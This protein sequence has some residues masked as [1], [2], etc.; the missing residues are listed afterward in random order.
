M[1]T[2]YSGKLLQFN[3]RLRTSGK[4]L[5]VLSV[6]L[7]LSILILS[8]VM[9]IQIQSLRSNVQITQNIINANIRTLGQTQ[10]EFLRLKIALLDGSDSN[11]IEQYRAFTSQRVQEVTLS[12]NE[13]TL[14]AEHLLELADE[15]ALEWSNNIEPLVEA[16]IEDSSTTEIEELIALI[17]AIELDYNNLTSDGELNRKMQ[18]GEANNTAQDFVHNAQFILIGLGFTITGYILFIGIAAFDY[19]QFDQHREQTNTQLRLQQARLRSLLDI[20]TQSEDINKQFNKIVEQGCASLGMQVGIISHIYENGYTVRNS[21][22]PHHAISNGM[23]CALDATLCKKTV[24]SGGI[25]AVEN[26][27]KVMEISNP[28]FEAIMPGSYIGT[29]LIVNGNIFG[30]LSFVHEGVREDHFSESERDFVRI[31]GEW[32]NVSLERQQ[33]RDELANYA[34]NLEKSNT[35]LQQF[36]Y[37]ASHDLQEPLRKIQTFGSRIEAK[38]SHCLDERGNEYLKRMLNASARMQILIQ[39]LLALSRVTTQAQP[40]EDTD[41]NTVIAGVLVDLEV[42]IERS[43]TNVVVEELPTIKAD[44]TQMRQLFQN[45][46]SNGIKFAK[47]GV[48]PQL[49]IESKINKN[50][51]VPEVEISVKDNGIGFEQQYAEQIFSVFQR[52]HGRTEYEGTGIGLALCRKIVERHKGNIYAISE[53]EKGSTFIVILPLDSN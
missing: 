10:R 44:N 25:L 40:L 26:I 35:E 33:S 28:C 49:I 51:T 42:Q 48:A 6:V 34:S 41:L 16:V 18:A 17:T 5:V 36:A 13:A 24:Q 7:F 43:N 11:K 20:A 22:A 14:G 32:I 45:L 37:A 46:I 53:P 29:P 30:T 9:F 15:L 4:V 52:L 3:Y 27:P 19:L 21:Y 47:E 50:K 38:Y 8:A 12:Y 1:I 2:Q 39:D 31:M 23:G